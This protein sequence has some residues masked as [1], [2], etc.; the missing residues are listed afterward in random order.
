VLVIGGSVLVGC[1]DDRGD[2]TAPVTIDDA[3]TGGDATA[4][5]AAAPGDGGALGDASTDT[6]ADA[7]TAVVPCFCSPEA[8]CEVDEQGN[9]TVQDGFECCWGT[10]C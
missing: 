3:A 1:A 9:S 10:T 6:S 5:D 4:G 8:C 2:R 7:A